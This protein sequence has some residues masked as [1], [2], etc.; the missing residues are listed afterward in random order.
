MERVMPLLPA[1]RQGTLPLLPVNEP[2]AF[3]HVA[4]LGMTLT[5]TALLGYIAT[6]ER[7]WDE[8]VPAPSR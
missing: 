2:E 3:L 5:V 7:D 8:H 1:L 6:R 4:L